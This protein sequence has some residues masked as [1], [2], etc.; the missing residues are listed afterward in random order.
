MI[1][2]VNQETLFHSIKEIG[3]IIENAEVILQDVVAKGDAQQ[4]FDAQQLLD[5]IS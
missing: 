3:A 4:Q 1:I 5:N 2:L